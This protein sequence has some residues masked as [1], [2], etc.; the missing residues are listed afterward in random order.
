MNGERRSRYIFITRTN[1]TL[2]LN[3]GFAGT[4]EPA[5]FII[6]GTIIIAS[7]ASKRSCIGLNCGK[8][9]EN[10]VPDKQQKGSSKTPAVGK[11]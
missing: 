2:R 7:I 4:D 10:I 9:K 8:A 11:M 1:I 3:W 6:A 5:N